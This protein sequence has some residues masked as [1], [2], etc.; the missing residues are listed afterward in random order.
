MTSNPVSTVQT[1]KH[2]RAKM[3]EKELPDSTKEAKQIE[4]NNKL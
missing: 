3:D 1:Q 4:T 2:K